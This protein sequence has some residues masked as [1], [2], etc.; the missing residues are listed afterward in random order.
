MHVS[1]CHDTLYVG[2]MSDPDKYYE[3]PGWVGTNF[4]EW[5]LLSQFDRTAGRFQ[6]GGGEIY[7]GQ[8]RKEGKGRYLAITVDF[9]GNGELAEHPCET[10]Q[11][12]MALVEKH[13]ADQLAEKLRDAEGRY[14][15][16]GAVNAD[17]DRIARDKKGFD[18]FK[19]V[20]D[21]KLGD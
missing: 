7:V 16:E 2:V 3:R 8:V 17:V 1:L 6:E 10:L 14:R 18:G 11:D 19:S 13:N 15:V 9:N 5:S 4:D 20:L 21:R 12:A